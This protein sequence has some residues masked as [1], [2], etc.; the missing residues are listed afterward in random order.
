MS[1]L[2]NLYSYYLLYQ[3]SEAIEYHDLVLKR[4][5]LKFLF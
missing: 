3:K 1:H 2:N 5:S 4:R